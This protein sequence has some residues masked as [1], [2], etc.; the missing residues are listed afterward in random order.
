M[1]NST[2]TM[3]AKSL[4]EQRDVILNQLRKVDNEL[5]TEINAA[6]EANKRVLDME[7]DIQSIFTLTDELAVAQADI[8]NYTGEQ[9]YRDAIQKKLDSLV[10]LEEAAFAGIRNRMVSSVTADVI[11]TF[12]SDKKAKE[13]ALAQA[14][15]VITTGGGKLGKDTVGDAF[16]V[17]LKNYK[18]SYSKLPPGSDQILVQ[19][20]RDMQAV[21]LPPPIDYEGG[22]VYLTHPI[23]T[24]A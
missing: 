18:E 16:I 1:Y 2:G 11:K 8:L 17:A 12:K 5:L 10:A 19:L 14:I 21:A 22:N 3:I 24:I 20:E 6:V 7:E 13:A 15:A 4:D 9:K 23:V